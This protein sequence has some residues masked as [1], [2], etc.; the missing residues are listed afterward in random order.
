[1]TMRWVQLALFSL[2]VLV[3]LWAWNSYASFQGLTFFI[4]S[5]FGDALPVYA[6]QEPVDGSDEEVMSR[7]GIAV[8][9][10]IQ[11]VAVCVYSVVRRWRRSLSIALAVIAAVAINVSV[12]RI[13]SEYA[14]I[15]PFNRTSLEYFG[16]VPRVGDDPLEFIRQYPTLS[17]TLSLH[18][19][20]HPPGGVVFLWL[21]ANVCGKSVVSA[22]WCA[23]V[24]GALGMLPTYWLATLTVGLGSARRLLPLYL[25]SPSL[26]LYG[27]TSMDVVF[28]TF[29][30]TALAALFWA[31]SGRGSARIVVAGGLYWLAAFM[32]FAV[33]SLPLIAGFFAL[34][35]MHRQPRS[36]ARKLARLAL[37]GLA[38]V[39][40]QSFAYVAV[41]YDFLHVAV[42]AM[43]RD[44]VLM[45][46]TGYESFALWKGYSVSNLAAFC[47]GS[48]VALA[49]CCMVNAL[50]VPFR[51]NVLARGRARIVVAVPL[52]LLSLS[53]STLF[54]L[55]TERVWLNVVPVM[56][57]VAASTRDRLLWGILI[58]L[59]GIQTLATE[60]MLYTYW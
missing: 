8:F 13:R 32:T 33:I 4:P 52:A 45:G 2:V 7:L 11:C 5:G 31:M 35:T 9:V 18:A 27:A 55:E 56:L 50:T 22:A 12:A 1:M 10:L 48:G 14:F 57:C 58:G 23:I 46:V 21:A 28:L 26:V 3:Q 20:T 54:S 44:D 41:G 49:A 34:V 19:G 25:V 40:F 42:V 51:S 37:V 39:G 53:V 43:E 24:F 36:G 16:D 38:F 47:F 17:P 59:L 60:C 6:V 30:T 15:E 29:A